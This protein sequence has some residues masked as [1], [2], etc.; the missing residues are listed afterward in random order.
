[1]IGYAVIALVFFVGGFLVGK[2]NGRQVAEKLARMK[3][4]RP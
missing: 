4:W 3:S 2:K 1:M